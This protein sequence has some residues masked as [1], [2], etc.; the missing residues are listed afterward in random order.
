MPWSIGLMYSLGTRA[1]LDVV[2]ELV[3]L[4]RLVRLDAHPAVAVVARTTGLANVLAFRLGRLAN[5]LAEGHLRLADVG[6]DL[7]LAL[8]AVDE[9]LEVQFAHAA[10]DGLA[11]VYIGANLEGRI[12]IG[13]A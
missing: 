5:R 12:F 3:A 4:A 8:H 2:D 11:R 13:Q 7:V 10:D 6:L 1:A 9:N